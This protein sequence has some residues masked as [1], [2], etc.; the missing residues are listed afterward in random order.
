MTLKQLNL[1]HHNNQTSSSQI[2]NILA[3]IPGKS[4]MEISL[5]KHLCKLDNFSNLSSHDALVAKLIKP[6][7]NNNIIETDYSHTYQ[8][9]IVQKPKWDGAGIPGYQS[10]TSKVLKNLLIEFN[11][12]EYLPLLSDLFSKMLVISA[13]N[14]FRQVA[15]K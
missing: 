11:G 4:S 15:Q 7:V 3:Y 6:S 14:N 12:P 5:F 1:V 13:E 9:F 10:E 2:D 8:T